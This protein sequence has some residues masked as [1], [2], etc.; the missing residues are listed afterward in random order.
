MTPKAGDTIYIPSA[1][2]MYR[3]S[4]DRVGGKAV[5]T[6]VEVNPDLPEDHF[7]SIMVMIE[8]LPRTRFNYKNLLREQESLKEAFGGKKWY[9]DPDDRK[10]F[11]DDEADW[12][13]VK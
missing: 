11:N 2:F 9:S 8:G 13:K 6:E 3:G 7:N 1:A 5:I 12:V 10:E 4:D